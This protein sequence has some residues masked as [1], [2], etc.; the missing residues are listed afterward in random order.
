M[1]GYANFTLLYLPIVLAVVY[2]IS[3]AFA[4]Q[5][6]LGDKQRAGSLWERLVMW[7]Y[8]LRFGRGGGA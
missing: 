8:N 1:S 7:F 2:V 4:F 6:L 3:I 5:S